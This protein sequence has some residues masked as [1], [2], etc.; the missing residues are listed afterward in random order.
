MTGEHLA[1]YQAMKE[2]IGESDSVDLKTLE[3]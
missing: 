3:P 2:T 1:I